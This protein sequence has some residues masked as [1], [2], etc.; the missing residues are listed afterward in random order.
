MRTNT[1]HLGRF[2]AGPP[3][4]TALNARRKTF[5]P[6]IS[7]NYKM[8]LELYCINKEAKAKKDL[9]YQRASRP[10]AARATERPVFLITTV[11]SFFEESLLLLKKLK[12]KFAMATVTE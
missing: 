7:T 8:M 12:P 3:K 2:K 5:S 9:R 6:N 4:S 1:T 10:K 11:I